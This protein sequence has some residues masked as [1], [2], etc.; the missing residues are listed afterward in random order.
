MRP[1]VTMV[2]HGPYETSYGKHG[3]IT[4]IDSNGKEFRIRASLE[5]FATLG[6]AI[7]SMASNKIEKGNDHE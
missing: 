1:V 2:V 6:E 4:I 3:C 7:M 5:D